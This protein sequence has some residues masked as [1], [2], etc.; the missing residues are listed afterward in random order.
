MPPRRKKKSQAYVWGDTP[1][2]EALGAGFA[3]Q[4]YFMDGYEKARVFAN[5][6]TS[7]SLS[8]RLKSDGTYTPAR[9]A[10]A[11]GVKEPDLGGLFAVGTSAVDLASDLGFKDARV[12]RTA[13][14]NGSKNPVNARY[15]SI[16]G[17]QLAIL[18][19]MPVFKFKEVT[20]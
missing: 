3:R 12:L 17:T 16:P 13:F 18:K 10:Y 7:K 20:S 2:I 6:T 9:F 14:D 5:Q 15:P 11:T 19:G 8:A 4:G 1:E